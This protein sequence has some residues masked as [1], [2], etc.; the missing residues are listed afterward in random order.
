MLTGM[1]R[2]HDAETMAARG[3]TD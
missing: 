3:F 2:F 1:A